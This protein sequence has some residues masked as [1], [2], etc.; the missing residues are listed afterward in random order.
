MWKAHK[1]SEASNESISRLPEKQKPRRARLK[2]R[3]Y[4]TCGRATGQHPVRVGGSSGAGSRATLICL[5]L[6]A[7]PAMRG[8]S[9]RKDRLIC[10]PGKDILAILSRG[11]LIVKFEAMRALGVQCS[12]A[13][14]SHRMGMPQRDSGGCLVHDHAPILE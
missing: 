4:I 13:W 6:V 12:A 14:T 10:D 3:Y 2:R 8:Y 1:R 5:L 11:S 7:A 9:L